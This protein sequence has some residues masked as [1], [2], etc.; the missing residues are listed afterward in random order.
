MSDD[1]AV[2]ASQ[3]AYQQGKHDPY[4]A[5]MLLA[6]REALK[7][8]RELHR[9]VKAHGTGQRVCHCCW[10]AFGDYASWPCAT[11]KFVYNSDE[12]GVVS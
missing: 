7:P 4:G 5:T 11:A 9:P 6:A 10:D 2:E 3:R 12:L 1:P 8:I